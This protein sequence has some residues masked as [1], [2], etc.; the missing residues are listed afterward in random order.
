[1]TNEQAKLFDTFLQ[2][3]LNLRNPLKILSN[4]V[5]QLFCTSA[6]SLGFYIMY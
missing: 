2:M 1:M 6:V 4:I 5:M 3:L